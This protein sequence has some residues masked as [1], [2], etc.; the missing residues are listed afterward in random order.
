MS[1]ERVSA[2]AS[3]IGSF[4]YGSQFSNFWSSMMRWESHWKYSSEEIRVVA[5]P[6]SA[7]TGLKVEPA[8]YTPS[9]AR[10]SVG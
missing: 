9:M 5:S 10:L 3:V 4:T 6:A 1:Q 2:V 7:V 8:G